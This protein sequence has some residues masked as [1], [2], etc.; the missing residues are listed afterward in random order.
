MHKVGDKVN[1]Q[2][3]SIRSQ[4]ETVLSQEKMGIIM[5]SFSTLDNEPCYWIENEKELIL[6]SQI[7]GVI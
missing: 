1:Y 3:K 6:G 2:T 5:E 7:I 4:N